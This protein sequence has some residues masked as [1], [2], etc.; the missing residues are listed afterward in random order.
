MG[1]DNLATAAGIVATVAVAVWKKRR[2]GGGWGGGSGG[3]M[4]EA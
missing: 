1:G 3:S 2:I 4:S